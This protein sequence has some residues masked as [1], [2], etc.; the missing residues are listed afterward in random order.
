MRNEIL[1]YISNLFVSIIDNAYLTFNLLK[2][3]IKKN[4]FLLVCIITITI[5]QSYDIEKVV[6]DSKISNII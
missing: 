2:T 1:N 3:S 6:E 5:M 4:T